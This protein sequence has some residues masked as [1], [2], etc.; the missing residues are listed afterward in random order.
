MNKLKNVDKEL[1]NEFRN[2][3]INYWDFEG[4]DTKE[5]THGLHNYPA[6]MIYPISRNIISIVKKYQ[7][8][9]T[10]LDPFMGS[11]TV[12]VEGKLAGL[13][14]V[15]GTD[16]N[17]LS[18]LLAKVKTTVLE[19]SELDKKVLE[20]KERIEEIYC[21]N[22]IILESINSYVENNKIDITAKKGWGEEAHIILRDFLK[23]NNSDLRVPNFKNMGYWFKPRV[24][25]EL[26]LLKNVILNIQQE[27]YRNFFLVCFSETV[28]YVCNTRNSEFKLFRMEKE[29]IKDF[30]PDVK[31]E[32][33][34]FLE[35]NVKKIK[36]FSKRCES[37]CSVNIE[38]E[39]ARVLN[40]IPDNSIDLMITSP[41][42][43]DS[44][45]TVAYGQFSR[46]SLWWLDL[47]YIEPSNIHKVDNNL[48]GGKKAKKDFNYELQSE[49]LKKS[50]EIIKEKDLNRAREVY[51]FYVDLDKSIQTITK[52]MKLNSYQFWVVGNRTVKEE[53]LLTD[54]IIVE[55][56]RQYGLVEVCDIPRSIPNK[57]MPSK[58]SPTNEVGKTVTTMTNE[59][60]VV[61]RKER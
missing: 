25:L 40:S 33:Y 38:F 31:T 17:P 35:R 36:E 51:S 24:I 42:Y 30:A 47:K 23:K 19:E 8:I 27:D 50:I 15:Y 7:K 37:D 5:L 32:F 44:K 14:E 61:L 16:L 57:V 13:K 43:G 29:K 41:P 1:I 34:K 60:I 54:R 39:D 58:N 45:T 3:P 26:Q 21:K 48:L 2:L 22:S 49:T 11:A 52:K 10:L 12:L 6:V 55:L 56:G 46:P 18:I 59:H 4:E 28:R 53:K 9:D 20:L